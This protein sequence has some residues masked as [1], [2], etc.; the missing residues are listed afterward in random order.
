METL[1]AVRNIMILWEVQEEDYILTLQT[2]TK[3][4]LLYLRSV[5]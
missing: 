5:T 1:N 4:V 2:E 3:L